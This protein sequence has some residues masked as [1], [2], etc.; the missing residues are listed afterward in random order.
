KSGAGLFGATD[1]ISV[2]L[3]DIVTDAAHSI[4]FTK[5]SGG[6]WTAWAPVPGTNTG[7]QARSFLT[8]HR[9]PTST[10]IGL[11]W[12]QGA[13][14]FDVFTIPLN[15]G[16]GGGARPVTATMTAPFTGSIV[17]GTTVTVSAT[18]SSTAGSINGVQ[19]LLDG[20]ALG[21]EDTLA[22]YSFTWNSST[23]TSG[24]HFLTAVAR[25]STNATGSSTVTVTV[26]I[27]A[28]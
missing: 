27:T 4:Q 12:T 15:L 23:A 11:G 16:S 9:T 17:S 14:A 20:A 26:D 13:S 8:G 7:T 22:P 2:W 1:C 6:T 21:A 10:Q 28:P 18:A 24:T 19:F 5:F 3:F 25:D